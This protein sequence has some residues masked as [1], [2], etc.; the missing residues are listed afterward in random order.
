MPEYLKRAQP[1]PDAVSAQVRETVSDI[2]LDVE[3]HGEAAVRRWSERLD[4][5]TPESFR[6]TRAPRID[7]VLREHIDDALA[8]VRGFAAAQRATLT[9]LEVEPLPGVTL[10]HRHVPV[11]NVGS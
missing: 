4:G 7:P 5:W 11:G 9:D 3:R 2:L 1:Q 8:Q 6:V 10:G